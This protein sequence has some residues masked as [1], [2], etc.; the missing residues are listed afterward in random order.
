MSQ[1]DQFANQGGTAADGPEEMAEAK[2]VAEE[3]LQNADYDG[4][5]AEPLGHGRH[6]ADPSPLGRG[7]ATDDG[8]SDDGAL[9]TT[10]ELSVSEE[11][12][13]G[14]DPGDVATER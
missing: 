2:R 7:D 4:H 5:I 9:D 1:F 10:D 6:A 3:H 12:E 14:Y 11:A 8:A 13:T